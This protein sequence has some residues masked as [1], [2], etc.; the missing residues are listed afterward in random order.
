MNDF[1]VAWEHT[2]DCYEMLSFHVLSLLLYMRTD[3]LEFLS[4]V[5]CVPNR[6]E[7]SLKVKSAESDQTMRGARASDIDC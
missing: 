1:L 3:F 2:V 6:I 7:G 5:S 4:R